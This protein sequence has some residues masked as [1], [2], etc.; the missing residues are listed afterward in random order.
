MPAAEVAVPV[1]PARRL[2]GAQ[3]PDPADL[4]SEVLANGWDSLVCRLDDEHLVR[5]P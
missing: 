2:L 5:L 1:G 3:H 4:L